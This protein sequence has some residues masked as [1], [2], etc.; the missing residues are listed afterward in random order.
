MQWQGKNLDDPDGERGEA[1]LPCDPL[2]DGVVAGR[3]LEIRAHEQ[4]IGAHLRDVLLQRGHPP[5]E[6]PTPKCRAG[7]VV[8]NSFTDTANPQ[9][10]IFPAGAAYDAEE[11]KQAGACSHRGVDAV[12]A[13]PDA[14]NE[15]EAAAVRL[16]ERGER[17][18]VRHLG[19]LVVE[20]HAV[21]ISASISCM[22][23]LLPRRVHTRKGKNPSCSDGGGGGGRTTKRRR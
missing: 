14:A 23:L 21:A 20:E 15:R 7:E 3:Q 11:I 19:V 4:G 13:D 5:S 6:L 9:S 17:G 10:S 1:A 22:L 18:G 2:V 12:G 16:V 8:M